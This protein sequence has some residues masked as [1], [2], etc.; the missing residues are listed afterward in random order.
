MA[1]SKANQMLSI[2][3]IMISIVI[4]ALVPRME[5]MP[6]LIVPTVL[7]VSVCLVSMVF[8]TLSTRPKITSGNVTRESIIQR[9]GNLLFFGN[10]FN[11]PLDDFQFGMTELI[12][13]RDYLYATMTR[14]LY[15]LGIVLAKKYRLL[16]LCYNV[17]MYGVITAMLSFAVAFML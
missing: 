8:A 2:N 17:F 11:L 10:Y 5:E 12:N 14:D 15:F 16:S 9:K 1:D 4:S 6:K 3:T 13:D 7:L